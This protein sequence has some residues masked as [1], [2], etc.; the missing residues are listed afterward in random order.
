[1][2]NS[3]QINEGV[4]SPGRGQ[5]ELQETGVLADPYTTYPVHPQ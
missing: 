1:M 5:Q 4:Q 3:G 2:G